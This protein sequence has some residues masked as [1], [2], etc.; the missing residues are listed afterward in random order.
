[1]AENLSFGPRTFFSLPSG[2]EQCGGMETVSCL[3]AGI[4]GTAGAGDRRVGPG[5]LALN[6]GGP[7]T[8]PQASLPTSPRCSTFP[9]LFWGKE[10]AHQDS[11]A[12]DERVVRKA[13]HL[14]VLK[15]HRLVGIRC[16]VK[17]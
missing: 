9:P 2:Q 1:M 16:K 15:G 5:W 14:S 12:T 8:D 13:S 4:R 17:I 6:N 7:G 11:Q 3:G 10:S